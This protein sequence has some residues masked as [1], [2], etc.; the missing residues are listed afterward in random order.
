MNKKLLISVILPTYNRGKYIKRAIESVLIQTYKNI[1]LIIIDDGSTDRTSEIIDVISKKDPRVVVVTNDTNLGL[2]KNLNKGIKKAKGE[3]IARIDDDDY[4][5]DKNKLKKQADF[6]ENHPDYVLVGSGLIRIDEN[7][8]EIVRHILPE[9]D[10]D[11]RKLIIFDNTFAHPSVMF[12]KSAWEEVNGYDES[13]FFSEDWDL[14]MKLGK[15]G[16]FYNFPEYFICYLQG[17]QNRSNFNVRKNLK[18]NIKLRK[19]Y[20]HDYPGF[21][22]AF[23]LGWLYYF[24]T[25][26]PANRFL[27]GI[28]SEIR[29][30]FLGQ[31]V[32]KVLPGQN[33]YE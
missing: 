3:L 1:E 20:R 29:K 18:L 21:R 2:V 15:I 31:P 13:L 30:L 7:G 19:R 22:R 28:F 5:C 17:K 16:K 9:K 23:I 6:L 11:I 26:L 4:W 27:K 32:Y 24:Y 8:K 14:W 33:R 12:K 25:F 10:E